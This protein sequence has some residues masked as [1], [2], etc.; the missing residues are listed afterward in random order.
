MKMEKIIKVGVGVL[1]VK[2]GKVLLH[3]RYGSHGEGEY[4][5]P[6]GHLEFGE[7]ISNCAKRET[8]EEA[9]I[10]IKNIKFLFYKNMTDYSQKHYAHINVLADWASG[11]PKN[12]EPEKGGEWGWYDLNNLP[13]PRFA[14]L[15]DTVR[16]IKS[17]V[18]FFDS[19]NN[20]LTIPKNKATLMFLQDGDQILLAMKKR[21]FG[22]GRY[23]GVGGKPEGDE[24]I[25][26]TAI[27]ETHEEIGVKPI[28]IIEVAKLNFYFPH[29]PKWDQQVYVYICEK[30]EG[31]PV[32]TEEM[33]PSWFA[34]RALPFEKMWSD[35]YLW[36]PHVLEDKYV[37]ASFV[38][39]KNDI[40]ER[41]NLKIGKVS[42]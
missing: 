14:T 15:D 21:G 1:V 41:Y 20:K 28:K 3:K 26:K 33:K 38:F 11:E 2:D 9:G 18:N 8:M 16:A 17:G 6:G 25:E 24:E 32:E 31:E 10:E 7:S 4:A 27:R 22:E 23:N 30:W 39:G 36:L 19:N 5:S 34:K 37:S 42:S 40:V 29:E 12:M 13:S 35:D